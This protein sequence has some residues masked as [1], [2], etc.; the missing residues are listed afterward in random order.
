MMTNY[1]AQLPDRD[2]HGNESGYEARVILS[3]TDRGWRASIVIRDCVKSSYINEVETRLSV[4]VDPSELLEL[5][6]DIVGLLGLHR[7]GS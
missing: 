2:A 6:R 3:N 5:A 1:E 4:D 7:A